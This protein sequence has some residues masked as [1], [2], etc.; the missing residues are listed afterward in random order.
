LGQQPFGYDPKLKIKIK[1]RE[2]WNGMVLKNKNKRKRNT[3][4]KGREVTSIVLVWKICAI[5][6]LLYFI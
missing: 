3:E 4:W 1:E 6:I 2:T 5:S